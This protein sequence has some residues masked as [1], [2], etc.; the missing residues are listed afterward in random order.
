[1]VS[2]HI[3]SKYA[4]SEEDIDQLIDAGKGTKCTWWLRR[5]DDN[6]WHTNLLGDR[7]PATQKISKDIDVPDNSEF[8]FGCGDS[9][10]ISEKTGRGC[11]QKV[12]FF[13]KDG[14]VNYCKWSEL[15]SQGGNGSSDSE[16]GNSNTSASGGWGN[17]TETVK[18]TP[19]KEEYFVVPS[20][21][22]CTKDMCILGDEDVCDDFEYDIPSEGSKCANC[23]K[24]KTLYIKKE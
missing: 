3:E 23:T 13:V 10:V 21:R 15:P 14:V 16:W 12:T 1:M 9:K 6:T 4:L 24:S 18:P 5:L 19:V 11:F 7:V 22:Y 17:A 20:C 8:Q 2:I